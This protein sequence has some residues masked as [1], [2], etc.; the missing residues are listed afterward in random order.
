MKIDQKL[1]VK[2]S[3]RV[4]KRIR[5]NYKDKSDLKVAL[6]VASLYSF[7]FRQCLQE[8]H[9]YYIGKPQLSGSGGTIGYEVLK[10]SD[11]LKT[12]LA[13][14]PFNQE[15]QDCYSITHSVKIFETG[16]DDES[17]YLFDDASRKWI[18]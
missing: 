9:K 11:N 18:K 5:E 6:A 3:E 15:Q 2:V 7:K 8:R 14:K 17:L 10:R 16:N 1:L 13:F 12:L 4:D